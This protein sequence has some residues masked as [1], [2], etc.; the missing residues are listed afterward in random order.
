MHDP[1]ISPDGYNVIFPQDQLGPRISA[2]V[3]AF[4]GYWSI[5]AVVNLV[6]SSVEEN[7]QV[8]RIH[9]DIFLGVDKD[10]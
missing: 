4:E 7:A 8:Y 9:L 3:L 10:T 6:C 2:Q 5:D 1:W